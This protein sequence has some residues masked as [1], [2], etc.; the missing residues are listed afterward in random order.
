MY[1]LAKRSQ[2]HVKDPVV[3]VRVRWIPETPLENKPAR[4]KSVS[5]Q[6]VEVGHYT[7]EQ[8]KTT[9]TAVYLVTAGDGSTR[10]SWGKNEL[11]L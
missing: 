9:A 4:T 7:K 1:T 10:A 3:H 11:Y 2:T 5:L 8:N 6:N